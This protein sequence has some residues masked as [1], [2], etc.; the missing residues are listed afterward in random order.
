MKR[1]QNKITTLTLASILLFSN[2]VS[3]ATASSVTRE[4]VYNHAQETIAY[5][6]ESYANEG[7]N[8]LMD[9]PAVGLSAF[10]ENLT[11]DKWTDEAGNNAVTC[12]EKEV[13][14]GIKLSTVKNT[15]FQRTI[16][17]ITAV[18]KDPKNFG[19]KNLIEIEKATMLPN[20]HFADSV[21]DTHTKRPIGSVLINAHCFG[22]ISLYTAGELIPNRDKCLEWL[23]DKQQMDGGFT[24]DVKTFYDPADAELVESG[25]DMTAAGIMTMAI[26]GL[27]KEAD[28]VKKALALLKSKQNEDGG[29]S[30]WGADNPESCV[31]VIQGLTLLGIDP[32]GQ[33]WTTKN[34]SNPVTSLLRFQLENGSF[35]HVLN[36][37]D[38][39]PIYDNGMSTEQ[40]LYGLA[41]AYYNKSVYNIQHDKYKNMV[42][43]KLYKDVIPSTP[44]YEAIIDAVYRYD[45]K[46]YNDN[47][48]KPN[49]D[50]VAIKFYDALVKGLN[51][52]YKT[53]DSSVETDATYYG[54][55]SESQWGW[56]SIKTLLELGLLDLNEAFDANRSISTNEAL[57]IAKMLFDRVYGEK[58]TFQT[59][60][61]ANDMPLSNSGCAQLLFDMQSSLKLV[62]EVQ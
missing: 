25:I 24:W 23:V 51:L 40:G 26:L 60:I 59:I 18:G 1:F 38:N 39:L 33:E 2:S 9:W 45:M 35:T 36:E 61:E 28:P 54:N 32:M 17:G 53:L 8:G 44:H 14:N 48:F 56:T 20:G 3:F 16:I 6:H 37:K 49:N 27:D 31:W 58:A 34:G 62:N 4:E 42:A 52:E 13:K 7:Y 50:I 11:S 47:T 46:G 41:A 19:G 43:P 30:S 10:G 57:S 29:F 5:Y 12:R 55:L 21:E 22:V 15:D